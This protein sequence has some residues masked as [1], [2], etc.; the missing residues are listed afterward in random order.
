MELKGRESSASE[1]DARETT[2]LA[3]G[4][5][6]SPSTVYEPL[7]A[8][9]TPRE[10]DL[11]CQ[12]RLAFRTPLAEKKRQLRRPLA[13]NLL[14]PIACDA[15]FNLDAPFAAAIIP[16]VVKIGKLRKSGVS[17]GMNGLSRVCRL[18]RSHSLIRKLRTGL[19]PSGRESR[20]GH[21]AWPARLEAAEGVQPSSRKD[22]HGHYIE[23][24]LYDGRSCED[25]QG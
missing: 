5:D 14:E 17:Q 9:R 20:L 21:I 18:G 25:L 19:W 10:H 12:N 13:T 8:V 1:V 24:R 4:R 2:A 11:V 22:G 6:P 16:A 3:K 7:T 15:H 23:N